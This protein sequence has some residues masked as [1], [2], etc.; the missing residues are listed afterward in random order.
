[1][2][3]LYIL[4]GVPGSGKSTWAHEF[5]NLYPELNICYISRDEVR[6]SIVKENEEYFSH[7]EKVFGK[8]IHNIQQALV[9]GRNVIADATH[10]NRASRRKLIRAIDRVITEYEITYVVFKTDVEVCLK[11]NAYRYGRARV[12]ED[13]IR[14]MCNNF[15][16]PS[17]KEDT[18]IVGYIEVN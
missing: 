7:E 8:F 9:D 3:M 18:R 15:C 6:N 17:D 16:P 2:S 12:P 1:M 13:V 10:I 4:C 11:Q 5:I 14:N